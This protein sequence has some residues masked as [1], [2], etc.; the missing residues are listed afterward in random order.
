MNRRTLLVGTLALLAGGVAAWAAWTYYL[1]L[2]EIPTV[3]TYG[4]L[5]RLWSLELDGGVKARVGMEA[6][7]C[8]VGSG[9]LVYVLV[10]GAYKPVNPEVNTGQAGPLLIRAR[11]EMDAPEPIQWGTN[12]SAWPDP[13]RGTQW[14]LFTQ[15]LGFAKGGRWHVEALTL[16]GE[17]VRRSRLEVRSDTV[18]PWIRWNEWVETSGLAGVAAEGQLPEGPEL[19][20]SELKTGARLPALIP[21]S[22]DPTLVISTIEDG[23][24]V[25]HC[26]HGYGSSS[27]TRR[28]TTLLSLLSSPSWLDHDTST[29][30]SNRAGLTTQ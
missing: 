3:R 23:V 22:S 16:A 26:P 18:H 21:E 2:D 29:R 28:M 8:A 7:S 25:L 6:R 4:D 30:L 5:L 11:P 9:V 12:P 10:E 14:T 20:L 1:T 15:T 17:I 27:A 24:S 13:P 19:F